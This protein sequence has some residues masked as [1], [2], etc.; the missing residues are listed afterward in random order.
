M[1]GFVVVVMSLL[2]WANFSGSAGSQR[3]LVIRSEIAADTV[4][5]LADG[6]S[7]V[8]GDARRQYTFVV[9]REE[10]PSVISVSTTSGDVLFERDFDYGEFSEAE[11]RIS[12][13][14][15]GFYRT[16]ETRDTPVPTP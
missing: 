12:Y 13:D 14:E 7:Q 11:F 2:A 6:R 3:G 8:L 4:V 1:G 10:F 15:N 9:Q 5:R 16:T